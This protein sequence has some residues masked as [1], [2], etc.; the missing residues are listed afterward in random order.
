[1]VVSSLAAFSIELPP[2]LLRRLAI[3]MEKSCRID[4]EPKLTQIGGVRSGA[5][6]T[7]L[8]HQVD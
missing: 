5:F 2:A 3:V 4:Q 7:D 8:L 6:E 1:M